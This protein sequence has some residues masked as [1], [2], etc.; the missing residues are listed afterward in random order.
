MLIFLVITIISIATSLLTENNAKCLCRVVVPD[1][2]ESINEA[3]SIV[4]NH[5]VIVIKEGLYNEEVHVDKPL[6]IEASGEA[7]ILY[8]IY[9]SNTFNVNIK[10]ITVFIYPPGTDFGIVVYNSSRIKIENVKVE[11][12]AIIIAKSSNIVIHKTLFSNCPGPSIY[13]IGDSSN[14]EVTESIFNRTYMALRVVKGKNVMFTRNVI[15]ETTRAIRLDEEAENVEIFLNNFYNRTECLD[16]GVS[17]SWFSKQLNLGN[18][19]EQ[20][21]GKIGDR[22]G[23]GILDSP[24]S[25][26]GKAHSVDLYPLAEPFEKYLSKIESIGKLKFLIG[27]L[28]TLVITFLLL[29]FLRKR[30][31]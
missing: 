7:I 15:F 5:G 19:W 8:P 14:I 29:I 30:S 24:I 28:A 10:G 31:K 23:D 27:L 25:I 1:D 4:C 2:V 12:T 21:V 6:T 26:K 9:I 13:V 22:D 3:V 17:N 16:Y 20:W 18:Y 11:G